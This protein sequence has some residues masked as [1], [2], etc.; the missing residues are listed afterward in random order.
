MGLAKTE[1]NGMKITPD[2]VL[3][4]NILDKWTEMDATTIPYAFSMVSE[5]K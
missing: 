1:S 5:S 4:W 3:S 2:P